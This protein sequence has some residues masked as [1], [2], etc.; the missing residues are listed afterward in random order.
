MAVVHLKR[1]M[2]TT[3]LSTRDLT[4][5]LDAMGR[6]LPARV[7]DR[8]EH[9]RK[10][11]VYHAA[12]MGYHRSLLSLSGHW[13][14]QHPLSLGGLL[15]ALLLGGLGAYQWNQSQKRS[16]EDVDACLLGGELPP[17]AFTSPQF[18]QWLQ[19]HAQP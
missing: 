4:R 5:D 7:V 2:K 11:A 18:S 19:A 12:A 8:L 16:V 15:L 10:Q 13:L 1:A 9:R 3:I 17:G 6:H 14:H